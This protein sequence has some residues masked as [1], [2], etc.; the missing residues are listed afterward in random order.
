MIAGQDEMEAPIVIIE[1]QY[2]RIFHADG[3]FETLKT[4]LAEPILSRLEPNLIFCHGQASG[5]KLGLKRS[6][7]G[8][9]LLELFAFVRPAEFCLP[10]P[11]GLLQALAIEN[12]KID[13]WGD[14]INK[15]IDRLYQQF[16]EEL[17]PK[18]P[19]EQMRLYQ[20]VVA[21]K[22]SNW[23]WADQLLT[24]FK[25]LPEAEAG[26]TSTYQGFDIWRDLIEWQEVPP[27]P[28]A[29]NQAISPNEAR[30]Q[31]ATLL[32][33]TTSNRQLANLEDR[34]GQGDYAESLTPA[35]QPR[36]QQE[37]ANLVLAEAG[38]GIGKTLG[39]I[40]PASL[41]AERNG[42]PVWVSTFTR[43]LQQQI[44]QE[45]D[46]L[47]L[48]PSEKAK[49]VVIR[50]GRENYL[51]LLNYE[52]EIANLGL[53]RENA[54]G[55][56]LIARWIAATVNGDM[57]GSDFPDW[58]GELIEP[59]KLARLPD[60]RGECIHSACR[61]YKLCFI[62][63]AKRKAKQA[64]LVI[65]NHALAMIQSVRDIDDDPTG[66]PIQRFIFD[67]GHHLFDAADSAFANYLTGR[68][69]AE[70]R[71]WI[72]GGEDD[73]RKR[74]KGLRHRI[75]E[76]LV[77]HEQAE[78]VQE[79]LETLL[80]RA[81]LLSLPD[82]RN[83]PDFD[84]SAGASSALEVLFWSIRERVYRLTSNRDSPF[85]LECTIHSLEPEFLQLV[86]HA[87]EDLRSLKQ[88]ADYVLK[89]LQ[90][91]LNQ[92]MENLDSQSR[93][94]LEQ[95]SRAL[96]QRVSDQLA[97]WIDMLQALSGER[98]SRFVSWFGVERAG[99]QDIDC[100][101]YRHWLDPSEP[102]ALSVLAN[103]QG[104]VVTS[105]TL[106]LHSA[107]VTSPDQQW[108]YA[109][110]TN[111]ANWLQAPAI[112]AKALSPFNYAEQTKILVVNDLNSQEMRDIATAMHKLFT[113]AG[114]GGLG[115]FTAIG[116]LR[117][118][119]QRIAEPMEQSG[120]KLY[121]QHVD[122]FSNSSLIDIFRAE[123]DSC[124]LGTDAVRDGVDV[125]GDSLRL[126]VF[127]KV[128]WPRPT[129]LHKARGEYFS[130]RLG[131]AENNY[132]ANHYNELLTMFKLRQAF[133]RLIRHSK[134]RGVFVMLDRRCPTRFFDAFPQGVTIERVG[135]KDAIMETGMFLSMD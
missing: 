16:C 96:E 68:E 109:E 104:V 44:Y 78:Q 85:G 11:A 24:A 69:V 125:P 22:G 129:L 7:K 45:C 92:D 114:G 95:T 98:D 17:I 121:A 128:P 46:R 8:G 91:R 48:N 33:R 110:L 56:G 31:L 30:G 47:F 124:L 3:T 21:M 42:A 122:R 105:A 39:Y 59:A 23:Y 27:A 35:F 131:D 28:P 60:R 132:K 82:W 111:G 66:E 53:F 79:M 50:K 86:E 77:A 38:T 108:R 73:R 65:A 115:L 14:A 127:D 75:E 113:A 103:A 100:G 67:E 80:D 87:I 130:S 123:R 6:L 26:A 32:Q 93:Q 54:I 12:T 81:S 84:L 99:G 1:T 49:R 2:T 107:N 135:I 88:A 13:N 62:E 97:V 15:V 25:D 74:G 126:L 112:R 102:F 9:D 70:L 120:F 90:N 52:E 36:K 5:G 94:R 117:A 61:H 116:R 57:S 71:R 55:L 118:V 119:Y 64:D 83:P 10:T 51:C 89:A 106:T 43:N 133:G 29:D 18:T 134:D 63:H 40:A 41:W 4:S 20:L 58:I 19:R 76:F 34:P 37:H 101:L 72:R